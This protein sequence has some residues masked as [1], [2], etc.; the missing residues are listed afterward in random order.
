MS[1]QPY[2]HPY[3]HGLLTTNLLNLISA[4]HAELARYA[5]I[6]LINL[7]ANHF[8]P[9][10]KSLRVLWDSGAGATRSHRNM[11]ITHV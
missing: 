10:F 8:I 1:Q 3:P 7:Y 9:M 5:L 4:T 6:N 2:P 11:A